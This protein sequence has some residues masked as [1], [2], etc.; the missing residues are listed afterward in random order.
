MRL[1]GAVE[2]YYFGKPGPADRARVPPLNEHLPAAGA[3][4]EVVAGR[5]DAAARPVH[6]D[7]ALAVEDRRVTVCDK[8][9][10]CTRAFLILGPGQGATE[11]IY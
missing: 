8:C 3:G 4:A 1:L 10:I 11:V 5:E 6:A 9:Q 7:D 2:R